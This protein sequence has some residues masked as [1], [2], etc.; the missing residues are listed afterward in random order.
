[1]ASIVYV[2]EPASVADIVSAIDVP[3]PAEAPVI[4]VVCDTV[5][6]KVVPGKLLLIAILVV[7][8][9]VIDCGEVGVTIIFGSA[10]TVTTTCTG[11]P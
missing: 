6:E 1:M 11:N 2:A 4:P 9:L 7:S 8:P 3:V 10:C 5:H